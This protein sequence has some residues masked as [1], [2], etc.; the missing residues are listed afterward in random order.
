MGKITSVL[1]RSGGGPVPEGVGDKLADAVRNAYWCT[2]LVEGSGVQLGEAL[3]DYLNEHEAPGAHERHKVLVVAPPIG[4]RDYSRG[5]LLDF[6]NLR[7]DPFHR[8]SYKQLTRTTS[9]NRQRVLWEIAVY[10]FVAGLFSGEPW[11]QKHLG[12]YWLF[13]RKRFEKILMSEDLTP[14]PQVPG[15]DNVDIIPL[16]ELHELVFGELHYR[17]LGYRR[18]MIQEVGDLTRE[19]VFELLNEHFSQDRSR[20]NLGVGGYIRTRFPGNFS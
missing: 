3:S 15:V 10:E 12:D 1:R 9:W 6:S 8:S 4:A 13:N 16:V 11:E 18:T 20:G 5:R 17:A 19:Q 7:D 2:Y 14:V